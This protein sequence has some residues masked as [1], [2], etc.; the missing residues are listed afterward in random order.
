MPLECFRVIYQQKCGRAHWRCLSG[1]SGST[2]PSDT[3]GSAAAGSQELEALLS[4]ERFKKI[5][6]GC[7]YISVYISHFTNKKH[8]DLQRLW[9]YLLV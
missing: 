6:R 3:S 7:V 2:H 8:D 4:S 1:C 5:L 9:F